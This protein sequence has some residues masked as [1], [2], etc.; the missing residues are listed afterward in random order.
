MIRSMYRD[1]HG[2]LDKDLTPQRIAEAVASGR[3]LL[4]VDLDS[5][6]AAEGSI[7][8]EVFQFHPLTI[9][10]CYNV[11]QYPK[12]DDYGSYIFAAV[13]GIRMDSVPDQVQTVELDF[14]VGANYLLTFH[15]DPL[16]SIGETWERCQ[17]QPERLGK[18]LDFLLHTILDKMASNYTPVLDKLGE[19]LD[20]L[21]REA[22]DRPNRRV[23]LRI[24]QVKRSILHVRRVASPQRDV[25]LRFAHEPLFFIRPET[26]V[27]FADVHDLVARTART[28]ESQVSLAEGALTVYL[29]AATSTSNEVMKVL[30]TVATIF[31]P[32]TLIASIYG[33]NFRNMPELEWPFGY[34]GVLGLMAVVAIGITAY[35]R[36]RRWI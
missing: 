4:W 2:A 17:E 24:L 14:Y 23:L 10:D 8:K 16:R 5:P 34:F 35:F 33:M 6:S 20:I 7:L 27:Y 30:S 26:R 9:E 22:L 31:M 18:G 11:V 19:T 36:W 3:G 25:L 28:I 21:E 1:E 29:S 32:L 15:L 13:H 12:I